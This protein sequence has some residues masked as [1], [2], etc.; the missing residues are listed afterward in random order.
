MKP[1]YL[2]LK[3]II[4][5]FIP[6]RHHG[7]LKWRLFNKKINRNQWNIN[8]DDSWLLYRE[9][10]QL[11]WKD[12]Q[13]KHHDYFKRLDF[14]IRHSRGHVLEIGC[15]IGTMT[16]WLSHSSQVVSVTAIDFSSEAIEELKQYNLPKVQPVHMNL[17][18]LKF[19]CG[20]LFD[21][22]V[23][24]EVMEHLYPDEERLMRFSLKPYL[25][26]KTCFI[27]S[28]PIGWLSDPFH[29]RGFSQKEFVR[30]VKKYYGKPLELN[31]ESHYSQSAFG[32]FK[33]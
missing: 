31:F 6:I 10:M 4:K 14:S 15:G 20:T 16:R 9:L 1:L 17:E 5:H 30:H 28:T 25:H 21:T 32:Y 27:I 23:L 8:K 12:T 3:N 19:P 18:E 26:A 11:S 33:T 13:L 22:V 29:T 24:C 7:V 2:I